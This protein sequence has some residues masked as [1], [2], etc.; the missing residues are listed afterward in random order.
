MWSGKLLT[1]QF[2][3]II[4][5]SKKKKK[6]KGVFK[7]YLGN[8]YLVS[9]TFNCSVLILI[10]SSLWSKLLDYQNFGMLLCNFSLLGFD[11][12]CWMYSLMF[13]L[14]FHVDHAMIFAAL[15]NGFSFNLISIRVNS[16]LI[17]IY[18]LPNMLDFTWYFYGSFGGFALVCQKDSLKLLSLFLGLGQSLICWS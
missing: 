4:L 6:R 9:S 13:Y 15:W 10:L 8:V 1:I 11:W 16:N 17:E 5:F 12:N 3:T 14:N 18:V 7:E 2:C